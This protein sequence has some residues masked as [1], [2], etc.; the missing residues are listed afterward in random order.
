MPTA[1]RAFVERSSR[2]LPA[3]LPL[4]ADQ[5]T[6]ALGSPVLRTIASLRTAGRSEM[7]AAG[8]ATQASAGRLSRTE[9][10]TASLPRVLGVTGGPASDSSQRLPAPPVVRGTQPAAP[11]GGGGT[12][13][14][15]RSGVTSL[16]VS[17]NGSIAAGVAT[18]V[19]GE[20]ARSA[21]EEAV[22]DRLQRTPAGDAPSMLARSA[23][24]GGALRVQR[25]TDE[26]AD[27]MVPPLNIETQKD[28][29]LRFTMT[30]EFEERLLE[31]LEDRLL[32]EIERRGGRY[33]G[34][35]A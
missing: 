19:A 25:A 30:D 13:Q 23:G 32:G 26:S 20:V 22:A 29:L 15:R 16:P 8:G 35:F 14:V 18:S 34:W 24:G 7:D 5:H 27:G 33:G 17:G 21:V 10:V 12:I 1:A 4:G 28:E 11:G 3:G 2:G 6:R 9:P 31:F